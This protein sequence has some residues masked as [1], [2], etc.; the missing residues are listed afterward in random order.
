MEDFRSYSPDEVI[1]ANLTESARRMEQI[2]EMELAHLIELATDILAGN[3][4]LQD[5]IASLS[6]QQPEPIDTGNSVLAQNR[7]A[8]ASMQPWHEDWKRV[9]LCSALRMGL[10]LGPCEIP[11]LYFPEPEPLLNEAQGVIVYQKSNYAD[12]AYL[13]F[14]KVIPDA[15][16]RNAHSFQLAANEVARG[17]CEYCILPVENSA[18]GPL[19][20][21]ARLIDRYDLKIVAT[22]DVPTG[23][24]NRYTRFALLRRDLVIPAVINA[25]TVFECVIPGEG[26][27]TVASILLAAQMCDLRLCRLDSR[28]RDDGEV[29]TPVTHFVFAVSGGDLA[30]YLLYLA[31]QAPEYEPRGIYQHLL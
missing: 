14:A 27:P 29:L 15:R 30:S 13:R 12:D 25:N 22:Y 7:R 16:A 11:K 10:G 28:M 6:E 4:Q 3:A 5:F 17:R 1:H 18:E 19:S 9:Q 2:G 26:A 8:I 23:D 21:F 20:S 24:G 31:M